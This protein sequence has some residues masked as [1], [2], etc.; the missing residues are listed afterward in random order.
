MPRFRVLAGPSVSALVPITELVN[1]NTPHRIV[2]DVFDGQVVAHIRGLMDENG[3]TRSS[4]YF[5]QEGKE[6]ITWS[7]QV[8]GGLIILCQWKRKWTQAQLFLIRQRE[9]PAIALSRQHIVW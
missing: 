3:Q 7:I 5:E 6:K 1:T 2:S 4:S 8:Q 9:I